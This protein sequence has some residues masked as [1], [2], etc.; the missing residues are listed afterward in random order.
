MNAPKMIKHRFPFYHQ[1]DGKDCGPACLKM[2]AAFH[3]R[4]FSIQYLREQ[5]HIG[6]LGISLLGISDAAEKTGMRSLA[7]KVNFDMLEKD[8]PLPCIVHWNQNHFVVVYKIRKGRVYV[9]D[10]AVGHVRYSKEEFCKSWYGSQ[11]SDDAEG[12]LLLLDP[13]PDFY[14]TTEEEKENKAT[15]IFLLKYLKPHKNLL[16]QLAVGLAAGS[17]LSLVMPFMTQALVDFG[18]NNKNIGFIYLILIA[19]IMFFVG[20]TSISIR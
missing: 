13:S 1:L 10:P 6:R 8:A 17:L 9:A 5:S 16:F 7:A 19:Q 3:G 14:K 2:I 15:F 20:N 18:I 12:V 4:K 11:Y